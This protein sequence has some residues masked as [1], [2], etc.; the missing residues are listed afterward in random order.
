MRMLT[1]EELTLRWREIEPRVSLALSHGTGECSPF[2]LFKEC[3]SSNA[4]AWEHEGLF[5]IT[6]FNHFP[7]Y[8]QLQIVVLEGG[9]FDTD[10]DYCLEFLTGF[11][12][13]LDCKNISVWGRPGWKRVLKNFHEPYTVLIKEV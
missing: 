9:F 6:R 12:K 10:W 11:A 5:A 3:L 7:Q 1:H 4:Q 13:E 2:D 8:K